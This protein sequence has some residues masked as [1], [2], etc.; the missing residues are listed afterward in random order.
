MFAK[1]SIILLYLRVFGVNRR[2]RWACYL[3][4]SIVVAYCLL[5]TMIILIRCTPVSANWNLRTKGKC[6]KLIPVLIVI[7]GFNIATDVTLLVLP[8]PLIW[9]L[10]LPWPKRLG[11]FA[12]FA[13]GI[14]SV[15]HLPS[16]Y[17]SSSE[18]G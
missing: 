10:R 13:T 8:V 12:A 2:F 18:T 3:L 15:I 9:K 4:G 14:L 1:I 6:V 17:F 7:G 11:V 16:P 5:C